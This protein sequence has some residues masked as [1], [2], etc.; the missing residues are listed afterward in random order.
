MVAQVA[1]KIALSDKTMATM[2]DRTSGVPLFV[3]EL[4]AVRLRRSDA[5]RA[6]LLV[7]TAGLGHKCARAIAARPQWHVIIA[8]RDYAKSAEAVR[9]AASFRWHRFARDAN[10]AWHSLSAILTEIQRSRVV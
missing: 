1:A 10:R 2:V 4:T 3:E 9:S 8:G 7:A 6:E 5:P